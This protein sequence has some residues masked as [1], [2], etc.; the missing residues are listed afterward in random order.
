M[1]QRVPTAVVGAGGV[2]CETAER[3]G[4]GADLV[5]RGGAGEDDGRA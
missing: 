4:G 3:R 5:H 1:A 2:A